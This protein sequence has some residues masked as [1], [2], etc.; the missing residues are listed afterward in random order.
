MAPQSKATINVLAAADDDDLELDPTYAPKLTDWEK[1][2]DFLV[3]KGDLDASKTSHDS[4]MLKVR[5][6][7]DLAKIQGKAKPKALKGRSSVQPRLVRR[8]AEWRYSALTE[9][10]LS[11]D[12]LYDVRPVT[13]E[14]AKAAE[15]N[16]LV[17]N[18]QWRTK[19]PR[20]RFIDEYVRTAVDE[21][22]V[23]VRTGWN[24]VTKVVKEMVPVWGFMAPQMPEDVQLLEQAVVLK[25]EDPR[26]F[27]EQT[28]EE[29][30]QAVQYYEEHG[31][32]VVAQQIG[33]E[34]VEREIVI[35]NRPTVTIINPEN[36]YYD[37]S[38]EGDLEK[39]KFV[40][41]SF[42]TSKADLLKEGDRYKNLDRVNW[43]AS[44]P[45]TDSDHATQMPHDFNFKDTLRKRVVAYEYWGFH[46]IDGSGE[47]TPIV[48]TW[49]GNTMI[50]MEKN[51]YPDQK[52]PFIIENYMPVKRELMGE[53][54]AELLGDN[55]AVLG[56]VMRGMIDL[57]GRSANSQQGF[58]KGMLDA[59]NRRRFDNGEN[60]EFNSNIHPSNGFV[61]HKYPE[62]PQSALALLTMQ[63][64]EA[65]ALTGVKAFAG[66]MS[67]EAYGDV[68]AGIRGVLD[69]AS[70]RE[71]GILRRL[72][73]GIKKIGEKI[74]AM[75]A[76]FLSEE[77]VVRITNEKFVTVKREELAGNFD[78]IVDISTAEVDN[79]KAQDLAFMLQTMG[80]TV[81]FGIVK[82]LL[83]EIAKLQR[84]PELAKMLEKYE[85]Q[86][87]PM[88]EA[89][90]QLAIEK[91][92]LELDELRSKIDLN[93]ARAQRELE[94][95]DKMNLDTVEQET[96]T[97]HERDMEKQR[98]QAQGNQ[99]LEVTKSILAPRKRADGAE[100]DPDV[101]AA[102][103]HIALSK[104]MANSN[105]RPA[106]STL[107]RD[108][109]AQQNPAYSLSSQNY[110][111]ALDPA[112]NPAIKL[113]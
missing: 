27:D 54:D 89:L 91:A 14:D 16:D 77:E 67:G 40:I 110:D 72:A 73:N 58:A 22:S 18:S 105:P 11:A 66:G 103:G 74:I 26:S 33:E 113:S 31:I 95:A 71:M 94:I 15:Q 84:M 68:A 45:L 48:A 86:P 107:A 29:I 28:P 87:D 47:L 9:P 112:T 41:V 69:A 64:Q 46:D 102:V 60:Y 83:I 80:N 30:K 25:E 78:L 23:I 61:E 55:Q 108:Q 111:P 99:D 44:T 8:Q 56:A 13:F 81:D 75:N 4:H 24:R 2:P 82:L 63:N 90:K 106:S 88:E 104:Q 6:W 32:P 36:F 19:L 57:L 100:T 76:V 65:E 21:G 85:P 62:I 7:N 17:L 34:E 35:D 93:N 10:F 97:K 1:E 20:V 12:K 5:E 98:G 49:I 101:E 53:S 42:E 92:K 39:A 50:R 59:L 109:M 96:G 37:P 79:K 3:L 70:K 43:E 38:C 52:L 51:P